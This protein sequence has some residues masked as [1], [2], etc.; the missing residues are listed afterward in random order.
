MVHQH[1]TYD[2][3]LCQHVSQ[4]SC[5]WGQWLIQ[6]IRHS[7]RSI[8]SESHG[9]FQ[10]QTAF[11]GINSQHNEFASISTKVCVY[12]WFGFFTAILTW[13]MCIR[14]KFSGG[15]SLYWI[16]TLGHVISH[17]WIH[18]LPVDP[19]FQGQIH[20]LIAVVH[21]LRVIVAN[22]VGCRCF[23]THNCSAIGCSVP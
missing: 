11:Y 13:S 19:L 1:V 20:F 18:V 10:Q 15:T 22:K 23:G 21:Q 12:L 8:L 5:K 7:G 17:V 4:F 16:F 14:W 6:K 2:A 3:S 9:T